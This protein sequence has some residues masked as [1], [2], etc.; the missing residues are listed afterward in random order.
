MNTAVLKKISITLLGKSVRAE[1]QIELGKQ[2]EV[3]KYR[4]AFSIKLDEG[5]AWLFNYGVMVAWGA[6]Q[7]QRQTLFD[8][9]SALI[10]DPVIALPSEQYEWS[11]QEDSVLKIHHDHLI[12]HN[13]DPLTR[14]A[15]SHAFAQ[16]AKL[17][18]L[19]DRAQDVINNNGYI[20]RELAK[21]GKVPLTRRELAKLRG[22]CFE[23]SSDISLHY[24]LLDVPEFFW[25]YP[26]LEDTY[27]KL[28]KYL[29]LQP[30][31]EIL[32]KKLAT[33]QS[34]LDMLA[35][36]QYSKHSAFLEWIIIVLIA[37]DIVIYFF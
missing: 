16:S 35:A 23:T 19:E 1:T 3:K 22:V 7:Q 13:N 8:V 9:L 29:D 11:M 28:A 24:G 17:I 33:I 31:I 32:N 5:E 34:L 2:F 25:D 18:A 12:L 37:V 26:E 14:L 10:D 27:L 15:L 21:T 4:D 20:A 36:E 30:R 6:T